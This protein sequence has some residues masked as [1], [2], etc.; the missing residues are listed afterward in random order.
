MIKTHPGQPILRPQAVSKA[1]VRKDGMVQ[2]ALRKGGVIQHAAVK[3]HVHQR[4]PHDFQPRHAAALQA[5]PLK[6]R[7]RKPRVAPFALIK[8]AVHEAD[9]LKIVITKPAALKHAASHVQRFARK[10]G[11]LPVHKA[12]VFQVLVSGQRHGCRLRKRGAFHRVRR[13]HRFRHPPPVFHVHAP[14]PL[15]FCPL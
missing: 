8:D 12:Q 13:Q 3:G 4:A 7:V 9:S 5:C 2:L 14:T 15:P 10:T 1:A 6:R 11:Q